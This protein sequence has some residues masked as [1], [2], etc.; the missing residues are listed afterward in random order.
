MAVSPKISVCCAW[1]NRADYISDTVD[2]LLAQTHPDF[3]II[4]V[5]DGSPDPRVK[6]ILDSYSD[7]RLRVIHQENAGF[8]NAIRRAFDEARGEYIAIQG[9]GDVSYPDRVMKQAAALDTDNSLGAVGCIHDVAFVGGPKDGRTSISKPITMQ[10]QREDFLSDRNPFGHGEVMVRKNVYDAVGGYR[11][12]F[13]FA[14]DR[15]LWLRMIE[16]SKF[17]VLENVLYQRRHFEKDGVVAD[18]KKSIQQYILSNFARQCYGE[19]QIN[20]KDSLGHYGHLALVFRQHK[21]S[22]ANFIAGKALRCVVM[23]KMADAKI[24]AKLALQEKLT[25]KSIIAYSIVVFSNLV[26]PLK[27]VLQSILKK[28]L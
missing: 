15:D 9:A 28:R 13:I 7:P 8:V 26:P 11:P 24:C 5:N 20:G 1:Y 3:E 14:Q 22:I 6:G 21:A 27:S 10:P 18:W 12:F 19:R 4:I 23:D 2:S 25:L 16:H 17:L